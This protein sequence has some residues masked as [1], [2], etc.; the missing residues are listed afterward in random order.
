M[1]VVL[2]VDFVILCLFVYGCD[3]LLFVL[4]FALV[5]FAVI[6][7]LWLFVYTFWLCTLGV[8]L[9]VLFVLFCNVFAFVVLLEVG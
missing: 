8:L 1:R 4:L 2:P 7:C 9:V 5:Y 6:V 3:V